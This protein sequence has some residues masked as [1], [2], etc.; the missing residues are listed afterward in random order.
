MSRDDGT[1]YLLTE[2]QLRAWLD[3][4]IADDWQLVAPVV[5]AGPPRFEPVTHAGQVALD[6]APGPPTRWS[7]K[8]YLLP[9]QETLLHYAASG[10]GVEITAP[11]A[12]ARPRVLFGLAPCDAAG[13]QRLAATFETGPGDPYF[14]ARRQSTAI[15]SLACRAAGPMC[16]CTAV[17]GSPGGQGGSD[18][19]LLAV[20][21]QGESG[22][23]LR[24]LTDK[25]A[26]LVEA[27]SDAWSACSPELE[28]SAEQ[29]LRQVEE[30]ISRETLPAATPGLLEQGFDDEVWQELADPCLGCRVCT[31]VCPS[32][33]CFDVYDEGTAACGQR[34][35]CWDGCT[36]ALFTAHATGH[37]PRPTQAARL[38]QRVMHK[39]SYFPSEHAGRSMCVGCGRCAVSCPA[40]LDLH[41]T[42]MRVLE[43]TASAEGAGHA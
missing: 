2:T 35:R 3:E 10:A 5:D 16:F 18:V 22:F 4:L 23:I 24:P 31:M 13:L 37:N 11:P 27:S 41:Q 7:A 38:R 36:Q 30:T 8:E 15:V 32:C 29:R 33:S 19:Q 20:Q 6:A 14:Q 40:G 43:R 34:C 28:A 9:R 1:S 39:F 25:G 26:R 42:V 21:I 12:D 17:G